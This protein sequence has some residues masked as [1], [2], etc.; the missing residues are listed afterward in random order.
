MTSKAR[1]YRVRAAQYEKRARKTRIPKDR[2]W[3]MVLVGAYQALAEMES[4]VAA[5][6]PAAAA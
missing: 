5:P 3:Q 1:E 2:E 4:E 6:P